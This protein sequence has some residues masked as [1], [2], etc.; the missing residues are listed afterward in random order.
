M[1]NI[2]TPTFLSHWRTTVAV[3]TGSLSEQIFSRTPR[4]CDV[5]RHRRGQ[6]HRPEI[7][8]GDW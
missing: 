8:G 2:F 1:N 5:P 3:N 4:E 6:K 7:A